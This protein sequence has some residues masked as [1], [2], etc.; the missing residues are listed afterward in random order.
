MN[1]I[2]IKFR[3]MLVAAVAMF[4]MIVVATILLIG[5]KQIANEMAQLNELGTLAPIV[6][7]VVHEMQKERGMSA[8]FIG[9]EGKSF[10][11]ELSQQ[12]QLT[13]SKR[14]DLAR[15]L[16]NFD[17]GSFGEK[18]VAKINSVNGALEGMAAVRSSVSNLDSTTGKMAS[19]YSDTIDSLLAVIEELGTLSSDADVTRAIAA[20]TNFLEGKERA[21]RERAMGADGFGR[22]EFLP[23]VFI[24]F[25]KL[26]GQQQVLF[27]NFKQY[28]TDEQVKFFDSTLSGNTIS[29]VQ[30]MREIAFESKDTGDTGDFKGSY[31]FEEITKK[32]N[33]LKIVEDRI[34]SNLLTLTSD[35]QTTA[36]TA[37][38][39]LGGAILAL[40]I[41]VAALAYFII[42]GITGPIQNMTSVMDQLAHGNIEVEVH[43]QEQGDEIG[44]MARAVQIFK[45][46]AVEK[47]RLEEEEMRAEDRQNREMEE[48]QRERDERQ[49]ERE[50]RELE[51]DENAKREASRKRLNELTDEFGV[52]IEQVLEIVSSQS[53]QMQSSAQ[54]MADIATRTQGEST[55]VSTAAE[56]ATASVQSVASAA[57]ELSSSITEI[58]RQV[59]HSSNISNDAVGAARETSKTIN[60]LAEGADKIGEV[61]TLINDIADQT[62][63]LALNAT[64]EAAR[65]GDAGKGF[66]VVAS[67]VKNLASQTSKATDEIG[68]RISEI[69]V[70]TREAVGAIEA[71]SSRISQMNEIATSIASAVEEQGAA[72]G[73][74]SRS[75]QDAANGTNEVSSSITR[76]KEGSEETGN[77]AGE[78]LVASRDLSSR[79]DTLRS[80]VGEFLANVKAV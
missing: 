55:T 63:L 78:V 15:S 49:R 64:I 33:L 73:E 23:H 35:I 32:I 7:G 11:S 47:S 75:V 66:A 36:S 19:Y 71:I 9:S 62:N 5:K 30:R 52:K 48:R 50:E 39:V 17:A 12:K 21:G 79:F 60:E 58:S 61:V 16:K 2:S 59:S 65:A 74:I 22:G 70:T 3:I 72:T 53:I 34:S 45:E 42:R 4:G 67:E 26:I 77:T 1:N 57:E 29:E 41:I 14:S 10:I 51:N 76:V 68:M 40:V 31:W 80:E 54:S 38:Y 28:G 43:A 56:E 6:S 20:Y 69:Q 37:L 27:S 24:N 25:V 44:E 46:N 18:L 13:D 8:V